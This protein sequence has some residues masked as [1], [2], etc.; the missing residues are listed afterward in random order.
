MS[1]V[2]KN[3]AGKTEVNLQFCLKF[4]LQESGIV[5]SVEVKLSPEIL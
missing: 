4:W 1:G 5:L 3:L 2:D